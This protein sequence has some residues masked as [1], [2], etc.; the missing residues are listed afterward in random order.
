MKDMFEATYSLAAQK[1]TPKSPVNLAIDELRPGPNSMGGVPFSSGGGKFYTP[2]RM[3]SLRATEAI[4][5]SRRKR[6]EDLNPRP[7]FYGDAW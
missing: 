3:R 5:N 1:T 6:G 7:L 2:S 4:Q